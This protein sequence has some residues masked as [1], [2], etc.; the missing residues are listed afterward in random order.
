MKS[1]LRNILLTYLVHFA[2][3]KCLLI[4]IFSIFSLILQLVLIVIGAVAVVSVLQPYIFLATVPVM[5][6]FIMLRGYFLH[7]SQQLKQ[8]ESEGVMLNVQWSPRKISTRA[9]CDS[10]LLI[11]FSKKFF[12]AFKLLHYITVT[13]KKCMYIKRNSKLQSTHRLF[14]LIKTIWVHF[15]FKTTV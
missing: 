9:I 12:P 11:Y 10:P 13:F 14:L 3:W 4:N 7:T 1:L 6:A 8:L 5:A 15:G 2:T